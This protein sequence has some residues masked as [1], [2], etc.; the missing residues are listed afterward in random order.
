L[1]FTYFLRSGN[2][3]CIAH[4]R[5]HLELTRHKPRFQTMAVMMAPTV[6]AAVGREV[7]RQADVCRCCDAIC[8]NCDFSARLADTR[9]VSRAPDLEPQASCLTAARVWGMTE[10]VISIHNED[11]ARPT[12]RQDALL[13]GV[14]AMAC[15]QQACCCLIILLHHRLFVSEVLRLGWCWVSV[16]W[17][18][19]RNSA[20]SASVK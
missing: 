1:H 16:C 12:E 11:L 18:E 5:V 3:L 20:S 19:P 13:N 10:H 9:Q 7:T 8:N 4:R 14:S 6:L 15:L 2:E 17:K